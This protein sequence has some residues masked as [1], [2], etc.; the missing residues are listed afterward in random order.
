MVDP[1]TAPSPT[2]VQELKQEIIDR[3]R[4]DIRG[5]PLT[6]Q[7]YQEISSA[8]LTNDITRF[9]GRAL[10]LGI[11]RSG[12][13]SPSLNKLSNHL[14]SL[15]AD[16]TVQVVQ[17]RLATQFGQ[18]HF[19]TTRGG[20]AKRDTQLDLYLTLAKATVDWASRDEAASAEGG[21][22]RIAQR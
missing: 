12:T 5:F 3:G 18:F 16:C 19:Q 14:G 7:A 9:R 20:Q 21:S 15:G 4:A 2:K 10:L 13:A 17:E 11:S 8:D 6:R 22:A 1:T